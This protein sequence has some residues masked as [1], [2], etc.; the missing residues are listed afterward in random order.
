MSERSRVLF[1]SRTLGRYLCTHKIL[2][3]DSTQPQP[4][5][6]LTEEGE[7]GAPEAKRLKLS[8]ESQDVDS[9]HSV[10]M[11]EGPKYDVTGL[12]PPSLSLLG[13]TEPATLKDG[14]PITREIDVGISEYISATTRGRIEGI[15]KQ[16]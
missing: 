3:M 16:R 11:S 4:V 13:I 7:E 14:S 2:G 9:S 12:L 5:P 1:N 10:E 15:I 8:H 6:R